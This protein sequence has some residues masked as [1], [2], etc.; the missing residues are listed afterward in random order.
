MMK[1]YWRIMKGEE[2]VKSYTNITD[3]TIKFRELYRTD[4]SLRL[5]KKAI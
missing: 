3:A 4:N 2:V 1:L 5:V